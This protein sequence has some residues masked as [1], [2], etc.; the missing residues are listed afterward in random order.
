[1]AAAQEMIIRGV[2]FTMSDIAK[3]LSVSKTSLYE[4]F[5][6]KNE[7]IHNIIMMAI[8]DVNNQEEAIY[9]SSL[10][11]AEKLPLILKVTPTV[12]GPINNHRL[13][14]ELQQFYPDEFQ[15]IESFRT[16]QMD[17]LIALIAEGIENGTVRSV[18]LSVLRQIIFGTM[19]LFSYK[20]LTEKNKTFPDALAAM[21][22]IVVNGLLPRET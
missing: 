7:L 11:I 10:S 3:H 1:M 13:L 12:F 5:S 15:S 4:H 20:F 21:A 16:K 22:D 18:D 9:N 14:E 2:K 19:D 6:S 17:R 8:E